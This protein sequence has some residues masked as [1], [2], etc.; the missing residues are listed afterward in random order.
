LRRHIKR[1]GLD[2]GI[3]TLGAGK[4]TVLPAFNT[5]GIRSILVMA[6]DGNIQYMK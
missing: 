3:N 2:L 4:K 5:V 6:T 1:V